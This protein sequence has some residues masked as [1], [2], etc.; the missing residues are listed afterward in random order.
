MDKVVLVPWQHRQERQTW[1]PSNFSHTRAIIAKNSPLT[2]TGPWE[3]D[4]SVEFSRDRRDMSWNKI[5]FDFTLRD[6]ELVAKEGGRLCQWIV[7][8]ETISRLEWTKIEA[9]RKD[10]LERVDLGSEDI[11]LDLTMGVYDDDPDFRFD[12]LLS[13]VS[14]RRDQAYDYI[15][16]AATSPQFRT[17]MESSN[18][19]RRIEY[20]G[21]LDPDTKLIPY[22]TVK[23]LQLFVPTG[24]TIDGLTTRPIENDPSAS[25]GDISKWLEHCR[26]HHDKCR[27]IQGPQGNINTQPKR[28]IRLG[29][30]DNG[31]G[32]WMLHLQET[33]KLAPAFPPFAALSYCWGGD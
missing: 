28:V 23:G 8:A 32:S 7:E 6:L 26:N 3:P 21:L 25:L 11:P 12:S 22:R 1:R 16:V 5:K 18:D 33:E 15:L 30:D 17:G 9:W 4:D 2:P 19:I 27:E 10:E 20:F 29:L 24:E 13:A 14:D 31:T